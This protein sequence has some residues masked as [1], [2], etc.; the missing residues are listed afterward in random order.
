MRPL[1]Q[2]RDGRR[3]LAPEV[4]QTSAAAS[5]PAALRCLLEGWGAPVDEGRLREACQPGAGG[6]PLDR[7]EEAAR[8]VGLEPEQVLLSA[9]GLALPEPQVLPALAELQEEGQRPRLV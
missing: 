5:G 3:L 6:T 4:I 1:L 7:V 9:D 2:R 8:Q